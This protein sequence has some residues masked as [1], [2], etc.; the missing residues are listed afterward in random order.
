MALARL[1]RA[2]YA[3]LSR[4]TAFKTVSKVQR[5]AMDS[6]VEEILVCEVGRNVAEACPPSFVGVRQFDSSIGRDATLSGFQVRTAPASRFF[7]LTSMLAACLNDWT[8]VE[9]WVSAPR[10]GDLDF[11]DGTVAPN[12]GSRTVEEGIWGKGRYIPTAD[13]RRQA[14]LGTPSVG[15][16]KHVGR[17]LI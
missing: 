1:T 2:Q 12:H 6:E 3:C 7:L 9:V 15:E 10:L 5:L 8:G 13:S 4:F 14:G 11:T 16:W 17:N